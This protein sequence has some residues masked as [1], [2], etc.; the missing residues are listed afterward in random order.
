[1]KEAKMNLN[2]RTDYKPNCKKSLMEVNMIIFEELLSEC[3]VSFDQ[4]EG[5]S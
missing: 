3:T 4:V 5:E 2:C 1:M